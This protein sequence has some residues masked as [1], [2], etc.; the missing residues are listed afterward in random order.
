MLRPVFMLCQNCTWRIITL[1]HPAYLADVGVLDGKE[2]AGVILDLYTKYVC[3]TIIYCVVT[4]FMRECLDC[5]MMAIG[6]SSY[7]SFSTTVSSLCN[8]PKPQ[9]YKYLKSRRIL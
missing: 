4:S 2:M 1:A 8:T 3:C 5:I 6:A 9:L 7:G